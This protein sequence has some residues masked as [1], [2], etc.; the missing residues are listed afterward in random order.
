MV[1]PLVKGT[2]QHEYAGFSSDQSQSSEGY[3]HSAKQAHHL[4]Y[5]DTSPEKL[6]PSIWEKL[7]HGGTWFTLIASTRELL[8]LFFCFGRFHV[9]S[10]P[11]MGLSLLKRA[12]VA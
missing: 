11:K 3:T 2:M 12:K 10:S 9:V 4:L 6:T 5:P 7:S 1:W 8:T